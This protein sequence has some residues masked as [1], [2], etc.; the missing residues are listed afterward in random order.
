MLEAAVFLFNMQRTLSQRYAIV[1]TFKR[2]H[3]YTTID[4]E[5]LLHMMLAYYIRLNFRLLQR[6]SQNEYMIGDSRYI[7][8][9]YRSYD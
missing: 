9:Y 2:T 5:T 8:I 4:D 3:T 7:L 6:L 1:L